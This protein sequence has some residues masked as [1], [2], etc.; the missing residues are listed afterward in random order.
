MRPPKYFCQ[1]RSST[2][3]RGALCTSAGLTRPYPVGTFIPMDIKEKVG[4]KVKRVKL[5]ARTLLL[6]IGFLATGA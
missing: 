3:S 6:L 4:E 2:Y 5:F 1:L